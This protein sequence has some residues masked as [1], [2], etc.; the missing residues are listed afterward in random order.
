MDGKLTAWHCYYS[1]IH[2]TG[3]LRIITFT[4]YCLSIFLS[5][6][7]YIQE[8]ACCLRMHDQSG[9]NELMTLKFL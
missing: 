3:A 8:E 2:I 4:D 5:L 7:F 6:T 1:K 9:T